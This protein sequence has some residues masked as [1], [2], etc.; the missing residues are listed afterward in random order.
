MSAAP[1]RKC[2][3]CGAPMYE[4]EAFC[5]KCHSQQISDADAPRAGFGLWIVAAVIVLG[6]VGVLLKLTGV[7]P[8]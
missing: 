2:Y 1:T 5:P 3:A 8:G 7:L 4:T 6:L